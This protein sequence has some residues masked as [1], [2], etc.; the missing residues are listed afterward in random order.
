M[1]LEASLEEAAVCRPLA[2]GGAEGPVGGLL[3]PVSP[4]SDGGR[5]RSLYLQE[6][7]PL[8]RSDLY[9]WPPPHLPAIAMETSVML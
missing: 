1:L 6:T 7:Q 5:N 3:I 2:S 9:P 8:P 4:R